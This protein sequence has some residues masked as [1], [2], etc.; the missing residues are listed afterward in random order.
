MTLNGWLFIDSFKEE[1]M[2]L[3]ETWLFKWGRRVVVIALSWDAQ[4]PID[5]TPF[6][7]PSLC[8]W[9][10]LMVGRVTGFEGQLLKDGKYFLVLRVFLKPQSSGWCGYKMMLACEFWLS[11]TNDEQLKTVKLGDG[12][13]AGRVEG[14]SE[15]SGGNRSEKVHKMVDRWAAKR[16]EE[17]CK[18]EKVKP[19]RVRQTIKGGESRWHSTHAAFKGPGQGLRDSSVGHVLTLQAWEPEFDPQDPHK[20]NQV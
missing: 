9:F 19:C 20:Q 8:P 15:L 12:S 4:V 5:S 14:H 10:Y 16:L 7:H 2:F 18:K 13:Q 3:H 1:N 11:L 6:L 17:L